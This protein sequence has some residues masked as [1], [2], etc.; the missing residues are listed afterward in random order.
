[1]RQSARYKQNRFAQLSG[2]I[3]TTLSVLSS[4]ACK[5]TSGQDNKSSEVND[6]DLRS[7][8]FNG[9]KSS[10]DWDKILD[11]LTRGPLSES[12]A[13]LA[14][15]IAEY[16]INQKQLEPATRLMRSVFNSQ[17][18]LVS[19]IEL[20]RLVTLNGDFAEADQVARK[21]QLFYGKSAEPSLARA[22]I[23]QLKGSR[24]EALEILDSTLRKHPKNEEVSA[25]YITLL[26]E[27]GK[28]A[29]A[30]EIL[31][32]AIAT[33]PRSPYFLLRLA[34]LKAEEKNY[35][36]A[37][38]L[39]D[40]LLKLAPDNIEGW[41]LAGF[42]A[43]QENNNLAAEKY[44][45]EAY[46]K[47]PENDTL[48]RYYVTQLLKLNKFQEAR[49]LLLRLES[50][51][52]ADD[53]LDSDLT[54]QLGYVLFQ[55]EDFAEAKK[56]FVSLID[57]VND[58][59]RMYFYAAQCDER[60]KDSQQALSLYK[61]I[62]PSSEVSKVASQRI[63]QLTI[64]DGKFEEA[65]NLLIEFADKYAKKT[66]EEDY[67]FLASSYSKMGLFLKAQSF[68][69]LGVQ[70]FPNSVDLQYLK[71][72]YL[73]HTVSRIASIAAL[74]KLI[75]RNPDH[76]QSLNHLGYTL[77]EANQKLEFALALVQRA[78]HKDPKNGF[79]QDSLGWIHFKLK[80]YVEAEKAL[81]TALALEPNEPVILEHLGE[82][83]LA[84]GDFSS[85]LKFFESATRIFDTQPKW[86]LNS[87]IEWSASRTRVEKRIQELR[88]RA[89]PVGLL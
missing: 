1:M 25:R 74:E 61:K 23:A 69:D 12:E 77:G 57:K 83:K 24:D 33:M 18:T 15:L 41:T 51:S 82:L 86:K 87:D 66:L 14:F 53:Q 63:I 85:A 78:V 9:Q 35:K 80:H 48:A 5:T 49:R 65:I 30:K 10:A 88:R 3:L 76:I 38:N 84:Q 19:G 32:Q 45:R 7:R 36:D 2:V 73:E 70:K 67:K 26:I 71:A 58:K 62:A 68:A 56:R 16:F 37:K 42:I 44:F 27:S 13:D 52:D 20:V 34:R 46:E 60:L 8:D 54:F 11:Q 47:Q 79:Y 31:M 64:E 89:L 22:Y 81:N 59:D 40:K 72:A 17:P 4:T 50:T 75:A 39:L 28:K 21:L 6:F 29:K 55:L 43:T